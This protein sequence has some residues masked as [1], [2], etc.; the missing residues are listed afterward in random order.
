MKT[1]KAEE[2]IRAGQDCCLPE[3]SPEYT[4]RI[5][6]GKTGGAGYTQP[7]K[8]RVGLINEDESHLPCGVKGKNVFIQ[9]LIV[10][11]P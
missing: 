11:S 2:V 3:E 7:L 4:L 1:H 8:E 10:R 6:T 5:K 9:K